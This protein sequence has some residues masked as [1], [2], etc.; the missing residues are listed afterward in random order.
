MFSLTE[1]LSQSCSSLL[2]RSELSS[3]QLADEKQG[4]PAGAF[5]IV[6]CHF[7]PMLKLLNAQM[8]GDLDRFDPDTLTPFRM[9]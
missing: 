6:W 7:L 5:V 1:T 2:C 9:I 4:V 3:T 8:G